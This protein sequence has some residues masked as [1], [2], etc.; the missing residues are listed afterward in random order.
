MVVG[1]WFSV[2]GNW[3]NSISP[4]IHKYSMYL[5]HNQKPTTHNLLRDLYDILLPRLC[6]VCGRTMESYEHLM[7]TSCYIIMPRLNQINS[8][9]NEMT[10]SLSDSVPVEYANAWMIYNKMSQY[11]SLTSGFKFRH[12]DTWAIKLGQ[13]AYIE[14]GKEL[15]RWGIDAIAPVPLSKKRFWQ[16]GYNQ[17]E[18]IA[19]GFS[20]EMDIPIMSILKRKRQGKSQ[21]QLSRI[22][23]SENVHDIYQAHIP[24]GWQGRHWMIVDDVFTTGATMKNCALAILKADKTAKISI[25]ALSRNHSNAKM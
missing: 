17:A 16:R 21:A 1:C 19:Q 5:T 13:L 10:R 25:F 4:L 11:A 9:D 14:M 3:L 8:Y 24:T 7:C 12:R 20:H 15:K 23:R 22:E 2:M 6:P 18:R